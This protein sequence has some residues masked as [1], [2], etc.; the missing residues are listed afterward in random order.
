MT[1]L[2]AIVLLVVGLAVLIIG[3]DALVR[4]AAQLAKHMGLSPFAIGVTVVAFGTSAPELFASV[5]AALQGQTEIAIGNVVGSNIANIALILGIGGLLMPIA[6]HRRV[7][8]SEIPIMVILTIVTMVLLFDQM[9]TR[10]EGAGLFVGLILYV[11]YIVKTHKEDIEH[12]LDDAVGK[13][14]PVW[15]DL[16]YIILGCVGLGIGAKVLVIGATDLAQAVGISAGIIATTIVAFGTSVPELAATIRAAAAKQADMA[17]GNIVGSNVFNLLSVLGVTALI[18]PLNMDHSMNWH[19]WVMLVVAILLMIWTLVRPVIA[20]GFGV[21]FLLVYL[22]Y[23]VLS[24]A[25]IPALS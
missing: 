20:K 13:I 11:I 6:V 5:G 1:H 22:G 8:M 10:I 2:I 4:G 9:L 25:E 16:L 19:L 23:V 21:L 17:V 7:R 3:A 15:I 24:Y 14:K 12:G 18:K